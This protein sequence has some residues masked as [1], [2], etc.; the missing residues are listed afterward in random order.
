MRPRDHGSQNIPCQQ[1]KYKT[2]KIALFGLAADDEVT[3]CISEQEKRAASAR[4]ISYV[5]IVLPPP[6]GFMLDTAT[7]YGGPLVY[8]IHAC[9]MSWIP[10]GHCHRRP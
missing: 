7:I 1:D 3:T 9:M 10:L 2:R 6:G 5:I 8:K 4:H